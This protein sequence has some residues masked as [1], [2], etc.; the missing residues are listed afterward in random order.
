VLSD[1]S[2]TDQVIYSKHSPAFVD[3]AKYESIAVTAKASV[4]E[5]T[6][7]NQCEPGTLDNK[8]ERKDFQF[9][10]SFGIEQ[11]K[12]FFSQNIILV[13]GEEDVVG[14]LAT[15]RHLGLFR[16]FPEEIGYTLIPTQSKNEMPKYIKL[17][18]GF[19]IPYTI[20]HEL[21]GTPDS[22]ENKVIRD[23]CGNN[24]RVELPNRL[25]E[26]AGH[27]GHFR[28]LYSAMKFF[29]NADNIAQP[30]K[31]AVAELFK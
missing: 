17:L 21:D 12:M 5:G 13:E 29:E 14:V 10:S 9:F 28:K 15:G 24:K 11:N 19:G 16:E 1:F 25:E 27:Q 31:D 22:D 18:N 3:V 26:A 20:L 23:L 8:N 6:T 4:A 7:I 30:L 2:A